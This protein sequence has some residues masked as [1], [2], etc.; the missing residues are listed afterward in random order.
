MRPRALDGEELLLWIVSRTV[1]NPTTGCYLW[2][3][4]TSG[5]VDPDDL[6]GSR[7]RGYP[8]MRYRGKMEYV[9]RVVLRLLGVKFRR[10]RQHQSEHICRTR[11]CVRPEHLERLTQSQNIRRSYAARRV[12]RVCEESCA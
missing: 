11:L 3:G 9:H 12:A 4:A 1:V 7:G 8:K 10:D 2:T 5:E 6:R